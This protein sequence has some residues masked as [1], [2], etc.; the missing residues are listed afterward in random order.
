M[1]KRIFISFAA[2]DISSRDLLVGQAR[3]KK[4][5]F[6]F[7]DMSVKEPWK[8]DWKDK[9]R[10]KIKGC[11]GVIVMVSGK[12]CYAN[13]AKHEMKCANEEDIPMRGIYISSDDKDKITLPDELKGK[14]VVYWTWDNIEAFVDSL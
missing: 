5:P 4:S 9:C 1:A 3:N 12:T 13:G 11:D 2:E 8:E 6:E 7:V 10:T 14:R